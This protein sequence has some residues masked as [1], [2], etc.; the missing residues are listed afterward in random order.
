MTTTID[1][2]TVQ[3]V[4]D[5]MTASINGFMDSRPT[6][7]FGSIIYGANK[8]LALRDYIVGLP[9]T[10]SLD[11]ARNY[12]ESILH[13]AVGK[14]RAPFISTLA[15]FAYEEGY[16]ESA[17]EYLDDDAVAGYSLA[18]LLRRVISSNWPPEYLSSMRWDLHSRVLE[19]ISEMADQLVSE[20]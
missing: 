5:V 14:D 17:L 2:M 10:M 13:Q 16:E 1:R 19:Q 18:E 6:N 15:F 4:M 8:C 11:D 12:V 3:E 7:D 9:F 20:L